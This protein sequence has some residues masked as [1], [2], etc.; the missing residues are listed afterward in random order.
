MGLLALLA[1]YAATLVPG[2]FLSGL[3]RVLPALLG[4][5]AASAGLWWWSRRRHDAQLQ[6]AVRAVVAIGEGRTQ[7]L[8]LRNVSGDLAPLLHALQDA[9]DSSPSASM[10]WSK[11]CAMASS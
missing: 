1:C 2:G 6:Q 8:D 4:L 5:G 11:A 10:S 3:G 9:Q 7:R